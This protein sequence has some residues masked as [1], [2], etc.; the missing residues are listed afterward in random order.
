[1]SKLRFLGAF[2]VFFFF[3]FLFFGDG[4][5]KLVNSPPQEKQLG[6]HPI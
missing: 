2:K 5:I 6:R 3:F 1:M 4:P